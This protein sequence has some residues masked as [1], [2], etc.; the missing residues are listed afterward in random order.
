[1]D[2]KKIPYKNYITF[3]PDTKEPFYFKIKELPL[4]YD[5]NKE[6]DMLVDKLFEFH[7]NTVEGFNDFASYIFFWA[8]CRKILSEKYIPVSVL[9][10]ILILFL[11]IINVPSLIQSYLRKYK[12]QLDSVDEYIEIGPKGTQIANK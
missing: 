10:I 3:Q 5:K 9:K 12:S 11:S 4:Y 6:A 7:L 8:N 2:E 1:M